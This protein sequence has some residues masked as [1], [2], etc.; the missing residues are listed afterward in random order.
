MR[1]RRE[2]MQ[3]LAG[4][5]AAAIAGI[6]ETGKTGYFEVHTLVDV[7][8]IINPPLFEDRQGNYRPFDFEAEV[9]KAFKEL[10]RRS[11]AVLIGE[12]KFYS[13]VSRDRANA[14]QW[15]LSGQVRM[16]D[17]RDA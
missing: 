11:N 5:A 14:I 12:L 2:F 10:L 9:R 1:D 13:A 8:K 15:T 7:D 16:E 3:L 17:C 4:A 6:P